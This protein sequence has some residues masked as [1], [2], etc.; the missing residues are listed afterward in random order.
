MLPTVDYTQD[1]GV[2]YD[3]IDDLD[4]NENLNQN[5]GILDLWYWSEFEEFCF[6]SK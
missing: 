2:Y 3:E 4:H 1:I 6:I 5:L